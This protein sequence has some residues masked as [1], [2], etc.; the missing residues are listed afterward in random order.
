VAGS[1]QRLEGLLDRLDAMTAHFDGLGR[2]QSSRLERE[3]DELASLRDDTRAGVEG[4][5][6]ELGARGEATV[7][8]MAA[9][10]QRV[11]DG[12]AAGVDAMEHRLEQAAARMEELHRL[13]SATP[14]VIAS[15]ARR[16][17]PAAV[18]CEYCGFVAKTPGGL[19]AH[20]RA[21]T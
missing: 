7:D 16:H 8:G 17:D 21:H 11:L 19:S 12:L 18:T 5:L 3:A 9:S 15:P 2:D 4:L 13:A 20:R 14:A 1:Q 10:A 6:V